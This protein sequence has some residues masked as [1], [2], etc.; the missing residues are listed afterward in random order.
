MKYLKKYGNFSINEANQEFISIKN[1]GMSKS[2]EV[3]FLNDVHT[4][5]KN[6]SNVSDIPSNRVK[7]KDEDKIVVDRRGKNVLFKYKHDGDEKIKVFINASL[8]EQ[9]KKDEILNLLVGKGAIIKPENK[10]EPKVEPKVDPKAGPKAEPTIDTKTTEWVNFNKKWKSV[11]NSIKT[12]K[13]VP[14]L[15]MSD[16]NTLYTSKKDHVSFIQELLNNVNKSNLTVDGKYGQNTSNEVKKFQ[17]ANNLDVDGIVGPLTWTKMLDI[18][19]NSVGGLKAMLDIVKSATKQINSLGVGQYLNQKQI[20][21]LFENKM[22]EA[23]T[24]E[25]KAKVLSNDGK[26]VKIQFT[27]N[28]K[29]VEDMFNIKDGVI[30]KDK[31]KMDKVK[32]SLG[33]TKPSAKPST[34]IK[35][36][37]GNDIA[38]ETLKN[39]GNAWYNNGDTVLALIVNNANNTNAI[40]NINELYFNK[41]NKNLFQ[42]AFDEDY[43]S[44]WSV[45]SKVIFAT[46]ALT[47]AS[48]FTGA[49]IFNYAWNARNNYTTQVN[50]LDI[51][52]THFQNPSLDAD[53]LHWCVDGVGTEDTVIEMLINKRT[54]KPSTY[55]TQIAT[56]YSTK[57]NSML[58]DDLADDGIDEEMIK[59]I[60]PNYI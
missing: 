9:G 28:G 13:T 23:A 29:T 27:Y 22:N 33:M 41:T 43:E 44:S 32:S 52:T 39:A 60:V 31:N 45:A 30:V 40:Y 55:K 3:A 1:K 17:Q 11:L 2:E 47:P 48:I 38:L 54:N 25:I 34:I 59:K 4:Y 49:N 53:V 15:K 19:G 51:L 35:D 10:L 18:S 14:V 56:E 26:V 8:F 50:I 20:A 6:I 46:S 7:I 12:E 37:R 21:Q 58:G 57:Y 5:I 42:F 16:M 36:T 24:P